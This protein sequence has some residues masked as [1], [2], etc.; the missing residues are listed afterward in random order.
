[1]PA[2]TPQFM[3]DLESRMQ[4]LTENEYERFAKNLWWEKITKI[5]PSTSRR[6]IIYWLLSTATIKDQGKGGNIAFEDM[7]STFTEVEN[8][9]SG[10]GLKLRR[11]QVE[12]TDGDG[13]NLGAEWSQQIGGY[14][15]YYPQKQVTHLLKNGH[16]VDK[17]RSYDKTAF[18]SSSPTGHAYN[19]F[20]TGLGGYAN[21]FTG[22]ASG[23]YPGAVPIDDSV[24]LDV[25]FQN[26]TKIMTYIATIKMPNGEDPR[27]LRPR[28]ILAGPR[29]FPRAVQLTGSKF[30]ATT[31]GGGAASTD[32]EAL[33][34]A[35]GYAM[36]IMVDELAGFEDDKTF[37]VAC[38]QIASS[39]LGAVIWIERE[40]YK[41]NYY[42]VQDQAELDRRQELEWHC[43]GRNGIAPGHPYLLFKCKA[44]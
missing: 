22:A 13:L 31:V 36:P 27:Y 39:Q 23:S 7:V 43:I 5:R 11:A 20:A 30:I 21:L 28:F 44:T 1:M 18:F 33:I 25:A 34:S 12:D 4:R 10:D 17:Y 24:S 29:V 32:V 37:Y 9:Y 2:L 3:M 38:D 40:S 16:D 6:E 35:L 41:I 14:M 26:L 19:P 15:A 8:R 42:G